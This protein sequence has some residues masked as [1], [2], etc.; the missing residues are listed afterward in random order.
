MNYDDLAKKIADLTPEQ[1]KQPV[2]FAEPSGSEFALHEVSDL[3]RLQGK[4]GDSSID[5]FCLFEK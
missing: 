4:S 5:Q 1:R 2:C 3:E